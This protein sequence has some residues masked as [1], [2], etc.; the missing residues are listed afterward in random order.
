MVGIIYIPSRES[1]TCPMPWCQLVKCINNAH[2]N[3]CT[4][5]QL[6]PVSAV[7]ATHYC[8]WWEFWRLSF[9]YPV[10]DI[11]LWLLMLLYCYSS[12]YRV[13][14]EAVIGPS[15]DEVFQT[16]QDVARHTRVRVFSQVQQHLMTKYVSCELWVPLTYLTIVSYH[17]QEIQIK[18]A[19][20]IW[21]HVQ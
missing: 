13:E 1:F 11:T 6:N 8:I 7:C 16:Y 21:P 19:I 17:L 3:C 12:P 14:V 15:F 9:D 4:R 10:E 5:T 20:L 18:N 2:S